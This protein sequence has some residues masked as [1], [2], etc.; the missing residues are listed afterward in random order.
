MAIQV[1]N[2]QALEATKTEVEVK[3]RVKRVSVNPAYLA[4]N[5]YIVVVY[6]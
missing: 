1:E 3:I 4:I 6:D 5:D 2:P